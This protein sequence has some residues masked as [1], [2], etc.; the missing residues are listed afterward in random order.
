MQQ[1]SSNAN[2]QQA[3]E[4][5]ALNLLAAWLEKDQAKRA[6]PTDDARREA[7]FALMQLREAAERLK[8]S[9]EN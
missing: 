1:A 9:S 3:L 4:R 5:K 8:R 2:A 7:R 6:N